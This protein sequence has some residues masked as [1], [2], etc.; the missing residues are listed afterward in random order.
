MKIQYK[1]AFIIPWFGPFPKWMQA[2]LT[3]CRYNE[4]IDF[5]IFT[6]SPPP[7]SPPK[8]VMFSSVSF[9]DYC[10]KVSDRLNI[11][12]KPK[13]AYKLCDIKPA[14]GKIHK[15]ILE[16]YDFWGFGDIDVILGDIRSFLTDKL[17]D[18]YEFFSTHESRIAG[19]F[20]V[21]K[22]NDD[23]LNMFMKRDD[24]KKAF[25]SQEHVA[26]DEKSFS[27][28]FIKFKN[29]PLKLRDIMCKLF[30]QNARKAYIKEMYSTPG[31]RYN[32]IDGSRNFPTEWYWKNGKLTNNACDKEFL[33]FHF[34]DWKKYWADSSD[35]TYIEDMKPDSLLV[36]SK[37]GF[38]LSH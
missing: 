5:H 33:Y 21:M 34:L 22:N 15:D 18:K 16:D 8:N 31:L 4:S 12:F 28:L 26:F 20:T 9:D 29:L 1:I 11:N 30:L 25:E 6:D 14:Y 17:L 27:K 37:Q 38:S 32:W 36:I 10:E 13:N 24:W 19:H 2:Y 23:W 3:S 35:I 7:K